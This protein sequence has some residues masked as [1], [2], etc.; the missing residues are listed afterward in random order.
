MLLCAV[1]VLALSLV[2]IYAVS[3]ENEDEDTSIGTDG[4]RILTMRGGRISFKGIM[5][6]LT[7]EQRNELT[8]EIQDL[9]SSKFEEWGIELPEPILSEEQRSELKAGIEQ[10]REEGATPEEIREYIDEKL[11]EY[12]VEL[13]EYSHMDGFMRRG[14]F[15]CRGGF[16]RR[17]FLPTP[18][19]EQ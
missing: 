3:A 8:S 19:E 14:G 1:A 4:R 10:L 15:M 6:I 7:E 13:P 16:M 5:G 17:G 12:G 18:I 9:V 11:E 2:G